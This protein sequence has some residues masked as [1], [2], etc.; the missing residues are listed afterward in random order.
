MTEHRIKAWPEYFA[1]LAA[2]EKTFE[3]RYNDRDYQVGDRLFIEEWDLETETYTGNVEKRTVRY[4]LTGAR[5]PGE[6]LLPGQPATP[7]H[8]IEAGWV[9]LGLTE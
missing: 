8:A 2:G 5:Y 1:P 6:G 7:E 9:I 4:I 3:L